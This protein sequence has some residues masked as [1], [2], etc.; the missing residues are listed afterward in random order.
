MVIGRVW[1]QF[2]GLST[3]LLLIRLRGVRPINFI[4]ASGQCFPSG[5]VSFLPSVMGG[6]TFYLLFWNHP[7]S[8]PSPPYATAPRLT[9][10]HHRDRAFS[11]CYATIADTPAPLLSLR[12]HSL[13]TL[14]HPVP[15]PVI[16]HPRCARTRGH[17]CLRHR[18]S[19]LHRPRRISL[20]FGDH[21]QSSS[22]TSTTPPVIS[23]PTH[24]Q[25][26]VSTPS[27]PRCSG[28]CSF[29]PCAL[30]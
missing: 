13:T 15:T 8:F 18:R 4:G 1:S 2:E 25:S 10:I 19:L 3:S 11:D 29:Q 6:P 23:W 17:A 5:S 16:A 24:A 20:G 28:K 12:A 22:A 26:M 30:F 9:L 14:A 7:R 27:A 21:M